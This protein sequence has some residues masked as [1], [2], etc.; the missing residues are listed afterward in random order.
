MTPRDQA[1]YDA[2]AK[3]VSSLIDAFRAK[4]A[5]ISAYDTHHPNIRNVLLT[6]ALV[7]AASIKLHWIFAYAYSAS[8]DICLR[9]ARNMVNYGDI[10]MQEVGHVNPIMGVSNDYT[11]AYQ[12][13]D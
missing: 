3:S 11:L 7:D 2:A 12:F 10:N 6:H 5:P 1:A 13:I 9:A 4:L 8:K